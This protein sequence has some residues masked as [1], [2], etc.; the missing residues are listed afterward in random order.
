MKLM[1]GNLDVFHFHIILLVCV[2]ILESITTVEQS[3]KSILIS[4]I[5]AKKC[6]RIHAHV[7]ITF[8]SQA[9]LFHVFHLFWGLL[10]IITFHSCLY[11]RHYCY[12]KGYMC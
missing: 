5:E 3:F 11:L 7:T 6:F 12:K 8:H 1:S 4:S 2:F 10:Q 9:H